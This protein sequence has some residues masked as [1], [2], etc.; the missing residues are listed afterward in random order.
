VIPVID[1]RSLVRWNPPP[2]FN[3]VEHHFDDPRVTGLAVLL[4][5][6]SGNL[7]ARDFD[8]ISSY[9]GWASQCPELAATLPTVATARGRH[10]YARTATP[11]KT[12]ILNDGEL[13]GQGAYVVIPPS[14]HPEGPT[15]TWSIHP[16]REIPVVEPSVLIGGAKPKGEAV[17]TPPPIKREP[18]PR[19]REPQPFTSATHTSNTSNQN[20]P[21]AC[22][23]SDKEPFIRWAI[24]QTLPREFGTRNRRVF[25]YARLLRRE[26]PK[27]TNAE[28]LRSL[29]TRWYQAALPNIRTKDFDETWRD[30]EIAWSRVVW[31]AGANLTTVMAVAENDNFTLG[32]GNLNHEKVARLL[33]SAALG[34]GGDFFMDYRTMGNQVGLSAVAA[35]KIAHIL[36]EL[37]LLMIVRNGTVGTRGRATEWRWLGPLI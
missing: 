24:N 20:Q 10:V 5:A 36:I 9:D 29:V 30:F 3:K 26:F 25:D 33:R 37:G 15:Y 27:S 4:G 28:T 22:V 11:C 12:L 8:S 34:R 31:P 7:A 18:D 17:K 6:P 14:K 21:I 23:N 16:F 2:T 32:T 1:K 35:R 19:N 13:R